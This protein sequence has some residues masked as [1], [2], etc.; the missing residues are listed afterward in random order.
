MNNSLTNLLNKFN[1]FS[2]DVTKARFVVDFEG[3][4]A[5]LQALNNNGQLITSWRVLKD[6]PILRKE[7]SALGVVKRIK[8]NPKF[9]ELGLTDDILG[10]IKSHKNTLGDDGYAEVIDDLNSLGN[11]L[12]SNPSMRLESFAGRISSL[13][14]ESMSIRQ[15]VHGVIKE[16][17]DNPTVYN[18][19]L[20]QF[21]QRVSSLAPSGYGIIDIKIG[22]LQAEVKWLTS[23]TVSKDEIVGEFIQRDL[24][25]AS[26][27]DKIRWSIR[28]NKP[29]KAQI[30]NFL[31]STE[32]R[33]ALRDLFTSGKLQSFFQS[34]FIPI[35]SVDDFINQISK[36]NIFNAIFK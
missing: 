17:I 5:A 29:T 24:Y 34:P 9:A 31:S 10:R 1:G 12:N 7:M 28:G 6:R 16:I 3:D 15:G 25:S 23:R 14:G 20:V 26:S 2:D 18:N 4:I 11:L 27:L 30:V 33:T 35:S 32:G 13:T 19:G 21:E 36:D 22:D 8:Q